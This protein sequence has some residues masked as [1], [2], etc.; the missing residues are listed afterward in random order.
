MYFKSFFD[1]QLAQM[2]YLVGCQQTG[3][4]IIIDPLR[5]IEDY[6]KAAEAE[7]LRI[8][9]GAETHIHADFASGLRDVNRKLKAEL[10]VSDMGDENW[11]YQNMPEDTVYLRDGDTI[12]VGN[13]TLEV[14][15]TPG[16]TPESLSFL[17]TDKGGGST[18]P[19]GIFSGDFLFVGDVGRPDLLES[20]AQMKG[21][22]ESGALDMYRTVQKA[23]H[24]PDHL[25]I[26]PGHGAGSACGKSLGAVPVSTL[27]YE[28]ENNW[29]FQ[30]DDEETFKKELVKDQPEPPHYFAEMKKIN[31][32]DVP[33]ATDTRI[34]PVAADELTGLTIDLRPKEV[35]QAGHLNGTLNIP[36]N[37]NFLSYAGWFLDYD[38]E[39]TFIGSKET[40]DEAAKQ[41]QLIGYDK[42]RGYIDPRHSNTKTVS[43]NIKA[44]EFI[45][46]YRKKETDL[47][48]LDVRSRS[49]WDDSHLEGAERVLFGD[50]L[51]EEIPSTS[52]SPF[53]STARPA[54]AQASL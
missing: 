32:L 17:L 5:D 41:L 4:A 29:A 51:V 19:M 43:L 44:V 25:Q 27:G 13:I 3:D 24:L 34:Y 46:M 6:V 12:E 15:Y 45:K 49:E 7:G 9:K 40:A 14:L 47:N 18:V 52:T 26:W 20:A 1:K 21:T 42:V 35:Y 33:K 23:K 48:I 8:T 54:S 28:K 53:S 38:K 36:M 10:F 31:K 30:L 39:L 50:L 22:T 16:H 2:A 37:D 11:K